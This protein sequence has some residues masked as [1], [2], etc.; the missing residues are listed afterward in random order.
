MN[1]GRKIL[2]KAASVALG[3][4]M[5]LTGASIAFAAGS[6]QETAKTSLDAMVSSVAGTVDDYAQNMD[7][8][9]AGSTGKMTLTVEDPRNTSWS[10]RHELA[11][12][13][14]YGYESFCQGRNR[15][16]RFHDPFE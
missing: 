1:K 13:S 9:F 4:S 15:G 8:A 6:Y 7:K 16:N 14:D 11:S 3:S 12:G 2:K 10:G 5:V